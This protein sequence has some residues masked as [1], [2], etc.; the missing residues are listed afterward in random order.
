[1]TPAFVDHLAY[2]LGDEGYELEQAARLG[3]ISSSS[4]ALREAGFAR[5]HVCSASRTGYDLAREAVAAI[6][7]AAREADALL[8]TTCLPRNGSVGSEAEFA[9]SRDVK[10]LMDFPASRLQADLG[11]DAALVLGLTQQA[12]TGL[13]GSLRVAR[14]LLCAEP[15]MSRVL[16]VTA[17]RFPEGA[18]YEQ[19]YNLMSDGATA[20]IVSKEPRGFRLVA[21]GG[22]TS[23]GLSLVSDDEA[24]GSFFAFGHRV[25]TDVLAEARV[26]IRE[27]AWLVPQN[28]NSRASEI[29]ARLLGIDPSRV[30][31]PTLAEV[32]HV[33]SGDNLINL[34][35]LVE[36]GQVR[37]GD[38]VLL[39]MA[40]YGLTWQ[41]AVLERV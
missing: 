35:R 37:A 16:C 19:A 15:Q 39:F 10:H 30:A 21:C 32:G 26:S 4:E 14:A 20:C 5:H 1:L 36:A 31:F 29:L 3:R 8:Y 40:G 18:L 17:D 28:V 22:I 27:L 38:R 13:L 7:G 6:E 33:V 41:A 24:A 9:R 11:L 12:C 23:G 34:A 25:I 2:S